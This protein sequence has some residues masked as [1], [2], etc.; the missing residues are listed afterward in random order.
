LHEDNLPVRVVARAERPAMLK[1][2]VRAGLGIAYLT[3]FGVERVVAENKLAWT[4]FAPGV[5]KPAVISLMVPRGRVAPVY[6][7]A[8]VDILT[9]ELHGLPPP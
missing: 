9:R 6:T 3:A 4:P 2:L 1:S 7:E 8:L 5:I